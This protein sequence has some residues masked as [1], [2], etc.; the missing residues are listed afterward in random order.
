[1]R[2]SGVIAVCVR[3][4]QTAASGGT[5]SACAAILA[6]TDT[7][8]T[9]SVARCAKAIRVD[10]RVGL[11]GSVCAVRTSGV[12]WRLL[13]FRIIYGSVSNLPCVEPGRLEPV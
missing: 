8:C 4:G 5:V 13:V 2:A 7:S 1:M 6:C 11:V 9:G 10:T 12:V 3:A